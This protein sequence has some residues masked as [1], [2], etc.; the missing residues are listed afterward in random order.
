VQPW[1]SMALLAIDVVVSYALTVH[2]REID[3]RRS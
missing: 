2:G 3:A 1:L